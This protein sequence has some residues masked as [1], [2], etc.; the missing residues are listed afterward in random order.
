MLLYCTPPKRPYA[1]RRFSI[2][3][4]AMGR[5]FDPHSSNITYHGI[6]VPAYLSNKN[7]H[8]CNYGLT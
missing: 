6:L 1:E 4:Y 8:V 5:G 7:T 3:K 2:K